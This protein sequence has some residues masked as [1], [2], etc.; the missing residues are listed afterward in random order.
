M[1]KKQTLFVLTLL[2]ASIFVLAA[3]SG[4][5][6]A[7]TEDT[8][9]Q[10]DQISLIYTQAAE[11]LQAEVALTEAARPLVTNTLVPTATAV[12]LATNTPL[13]SLDTATPL[14]TLPPLPSPTLI[15]TKAPVVGGRPCLRAQMEFESPK[16]GKILKPGESFLKYWNFSNSG[17]CDWN[18]NFNLVHVG[19]PNFTDSGSFSLLDISNMTEDGIPNGGMLQI[20]L[21][22]QAPSTPGT[23][24]SLWMLRDDNGQTFGIGALG[25]EV[26]WVEIKVR[27]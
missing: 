17:D 18:A 27:E 16:D 19:G 23:Y 8:Q 6:A 26:F 7:A 2:L 4:G 12:I 10:E 24:R 11:T 25:N 22:M 1:T 14:P 3:C 15:P 5:Q 20:V 13:P 9:P 21:S